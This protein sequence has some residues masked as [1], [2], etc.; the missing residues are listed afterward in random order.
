MIKSKNLNSWQLDYV[1]LVYM[2]MIDA[3]IRIFKKTEVDHELTVQH[4]SS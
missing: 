3:M 1:H 2:M 4:Q